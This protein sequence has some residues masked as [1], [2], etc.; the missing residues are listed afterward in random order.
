MVGFFLRDNIL[1]YLMVLFGAQ[2]AEALM[3]LVYAIE[4]FYLAKRRGAC[5][6][7]RAVLAWMLWSSGGLEAGKQ[8]VSV[9][10]LSCQLSVQE[11][12][13]RSGGQHEG[14][15]NNRQPTPDRR[16]PHAFLLKQLHGLQKL[17]LPVSPQG[18]LEVKAFIHARGADFPARVDGNHRHLGVFILRVGLHHVLQQFHAGILGRGAARHEVDNRNAGAVIGHHVA[19][20]G[21]GRRTHVIVSINVRSPRAANLPRGQES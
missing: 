10:G 12:S 9:V 14:S 15:L 18:V 3:D 7:L 6:A 8:L 13:S 4:Y 1:A 11:R 21:G 19:V 5:T 17:A 2:V 20:A 16:L